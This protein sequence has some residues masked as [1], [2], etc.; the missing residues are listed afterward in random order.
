MVMII[1]DKNRPKLTIRELESEKPA[2]LMKKYGMS[3][4][5]LQQEVQKHLGSESAN[6]KRAEYNKIY[7]KKF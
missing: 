5:G 3:E 7:G 6:T 1:S 2:L 4:H